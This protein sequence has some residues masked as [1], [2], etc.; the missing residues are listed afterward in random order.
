LAISLSQQPQA[1]INQACES[2]AEAK[3]AYRFLANDKVESDEILAPHAQRTVERM[4]D[5]KLVLA[6]QDTTFSTIR[7]IRRPQGW[8]KSAPNNRPNAASACIQPW[9]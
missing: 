7:I 2:W 3:A 1:P 8:V 9:R 5:H 6:V 4:R